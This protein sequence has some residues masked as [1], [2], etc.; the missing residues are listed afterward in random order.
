MPLFVEPSPVLL[1]KIPKIPIPDQGDVQPQRRTILFLHIP[2]TGGTSIEHYFKTMGYFNYSGEYLYTPWEKFMECSL[3]RGVRCSL[4]H[5]TF[6][7]IIGIIPG[8]MNKISDV[9][10]VVRDP[11]DRLISEYWYLRKKVFVGEKD[12]EIWGMDPQTIKRALSNFDDFVKEMYSL[13]KKESNVM[14]N[15]FL[16]Q[17]R[18][19]ENL[20]DFPNFY[21]KIKIQYFSSLKD[22]SIFPFLQKEYF[23]GSTHSHLMAPKNVHKNR[24][25]PT[26][27]ESKITWSEATENKIREWYD[28]DFHLFQFPYRKTV[29]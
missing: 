28:E 6:G 13:Y 11:Y 8:I 21:K 14:D 26:D 2:K 3:K 9:F 20:K 5:L 24:E 10:V 17:A 1:Q 4:Q 18:F 27:K 29:I 19:I 12:Y 23:P 15:H 22:G 7:E 16:P 25:T